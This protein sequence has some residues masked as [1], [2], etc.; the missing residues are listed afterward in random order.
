MVDHSKPPTRVPSRPLSSVTTTTNA[1]V[2]PPTPTQSRLPRRLAPDHFPPQ[3]NFTSRPSTS[4]PPNT[5]NTLNDIF[6]N[7]VPSQNELGSVPS[8]PEEPALPRFFP[9][10]DASS[11]VHDLKSHG[12]YHTSLIPRPQNPPLISENM[13]TTNKPRA[14]GVSRLDFF[15]KPKFFSSSSG[16]RRSNSTKRSASSPVRLHTSH[17]PDP[18]TDLHSCVSELPPTSATKSRSHMTHLVRSTSESNVNVH[19]LP[20]PLPSHVS[21]SSPSSSPS[22]LKRSPSSPARQAHS[23]SIHARPTPSKSVTWP[24]RGANQKDSNESKNRHVVNRSVTAPVEELKKGDN[25]RGR[26]GLRSP[27]TWSP[28]LPSPKFFGGRDRE[29]K[30]KEK[31][32][33]NVVPRERIVIAI[34]HNQER[35]PTADINCIDDGRKS[36]NRSV[37][38]GTGVAGNGRIKHGSFDFE[39]PVWGRGSK[40]VAESGYSRSK[41]SL[42]S[43]TSN[44]KQVPTG[45]RGNEIYTTPC[46]I[47]NQHASPS[48]TTSPHATGRTR[49][50]SFSSPTPTPSSSL[51]RA[52][53]KRTVGT[54]K[55]SVTGVGL[56]HGPFAFE[57]VVPS[58]TRS[59]VS[60]PSGK[61]GG[62][63]TS[64]PKHHDRRVDRRGQSLD[65]RLGLAW[66]PTKVK[67]EALMPFG[68]TLSR[69]STTRQLQLADR[70]GIESTAGLDV[71]EAF[72]KV[73]SEASYAKFKKCSAHLDFD[74]YY[75]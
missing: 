6:G 52:N 51:G 37:I 24:T 23:K 48:S 49:A 10:P 22:H 20:D 75:Y 1:T 2:L 63:G 3:E 42:Q 7:H 32:R 36:T 45:T 39:K 55:T 33:E 53:S 64:D 12:H 35:P 27:G 4:S 31:E 54:G 61:R 34:T 29:G 38:R 68:R 40:N 74:Y 17:Q 67:E 59:D 25:E 44:G 62:D 60:G 26:R 9:V 11:N 41:D 57:P 73:L 19:E 70:K 50:G 65:L 28:R 58:P 13:Q 5:H 18:T 71:T 46:S 56:S 15:R 14:S 69:E 43:G 16:P 30:G 8:S 47:T 72:R 66:A 21:I